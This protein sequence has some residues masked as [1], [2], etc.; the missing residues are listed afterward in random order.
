MTPE[1]DEKLHSFWKQRAKD[2]CQYL[3]D[4]WPRSSEGENVAVMALTHVFCNQKE[5]KEK[6]LPY[7]I[8]ESKQYPRLAKLTESFSKD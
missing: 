3:N 1:M 5:P 8:E 6:F 2:M 7:I 4:I